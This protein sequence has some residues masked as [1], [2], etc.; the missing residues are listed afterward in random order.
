MIKQTPLAKVHRKL[1]ARMVD[2]GGWDMPV[3]YTNVIEEHKITR[4]K[5]GLFDI[6]HMGEIKITGPKS[7]ELVQM[8]VTKNIEKMPIGKIY[9]AVMCNQKGGIIDDLTIYKIAENDYLFVTNAGTKNKDYAHIL[10]T[11]K[12][13]GLT[14]TQVKVKDISKQTAKLDIQG[15]KS[16]L[17]LKQLT[18]VNLDSLKFYT[19][20]QGKLLNT[21]AIIS[22]SGYTGELGYELYFEAKSAKKI[23]NNFLKA[24]EKYGIQPIGLGARDTLRL[25]CG[26]N[27]YG[28][29][30]NEKINPL[31]ARYRWVVDFDKNFVGKK[32][33]SKIKEKGLS[34]QLVGF[35]MIGAGIARHNYSIIKN[36]NKIGYVTSGT[37]SPTL[38]K[39][40]GLGYVSKKFQKPGTE[41]EIEIRNNKT[42]AKIIKLP[43]YKRR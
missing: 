6:C 1:G 10:K 15:P 37:Y 40:I 9:L 27:L 7:K 11:K 34:K 20:K 14:N 17:I 16:K 18:K 31:I 42:K 2:F 32:A 13:L 3:F 38:G 23:W 24:G 29:E 25:E 30:I 4:K 28:H 12:K 5:A 21:D 36:N 19:F 33:L 39:P 8:V 26:M 22:R 43:F 41:I 35:E